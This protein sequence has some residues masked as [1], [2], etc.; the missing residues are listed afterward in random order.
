[1]KS[2]KFLPGLIAVAFI[3][4]GFPGCAKLAEMKAMTDSIGTLTIGRVDVA[5]V[6]D[7][8]YE[9]S[10]DNGAVTARVAVT[11]RGGKITAIKVLD[12]RHGP[13]KNHDAGA[14]S[15]KVVAEQS[16]QV[17]AIA[18]ATASSKVVLKAIENALTKGI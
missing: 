15:D 6:R 12:H 3:S 11:V 17:D 8:D 18:G 9:G 13:G 2:M 14:I 16:L 10:Q 1:M 5:A 4:A 7:G